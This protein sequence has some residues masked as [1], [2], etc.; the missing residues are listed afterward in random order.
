M[1]AT[2]ARRRTFPDWSR[3][4]VTRTLVEHYGPSC[5]APRARG[6]VRVRANS[7]VCQKA[8]KGVLGVAYGHPAEGAAGRGGVRQY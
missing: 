8:R 5:R 1:R 6:R 4:V 2:P 7:A 3:L